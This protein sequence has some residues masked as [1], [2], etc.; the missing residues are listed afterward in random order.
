MSI[1]LR[2]ASVFIPRGDIFS[3]QSFG[4]EEGS[5]AFVGIVEMVFGGTV[6]VDV[7]VVVVVVIVVVLKVAEREGCVVKA[8]YNC[9]GGRKGQKPLR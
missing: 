2:A 5:V 8:G 6:V 9:K 1:P 4:T 7:V 3:T